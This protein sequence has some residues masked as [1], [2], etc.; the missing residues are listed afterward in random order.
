MRTSSGRSDALGWI[1]A[2]IVTVNTL[3]VSNPAYTPGAISDRRSTGGRHIKNLAFVLAF[4]VLGLVGLPASSY[5]HGNI[6]H[7]F[8]GPFNTDLS[9]EAGAAQGFTPFHTDIVAVDLFLTGDGTNPPVDLIVDVADGPVDGLVFGSGIVG[10]PAGI[11]GSPE[12]PYEVHVDLPHLTLISGTYY[13]VV[14]PDSSSI[15]WAASSS[16][17]YNLGDAYEGSTPVVGADAGFRTYFVDPPI[18][19]RDGDSIDDEVD[20]CPD[21]PN[22]D[23]FDSDF[24]GLGDACDFDNDNDGFDDISDNCPWAYNPDQFDSDFDGLGDACDYDADNDGI[25]DFGDNCPGTYNPDQGDWDLD[26]TG[27][28]C[29]F[30]ADNDGVE[31]FADNCQITYNP[32]QTDSDLDG[33]GDACDVDADNDGID[34]ATDNCQGTYNPDQMDFDVDGVGDACDFDGDNDGV[35]D[36]LDNCQGVYNP[37]QADSDLDTIGDAC[38]VDGD[39]DG[40]DDATDNCPSEPNTDQLNTDSDS[41]GDACDADDDNDAIGDESDNCVTTPNPDQADLDGDGIGDACDEPATAPTSKDECRRGGWML[42][43]APRTFNSQGDCI[44]FVNTGR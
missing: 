33:T 40:I 2:T 1:A 30:D 35:E 4:V 27:D 37:D 32:D 15:G 19:D 14:R 42:F 43:N 17:G 5:G 6:D 10:I 12:A 26:G 8:E 22:Y 24:D 13:I 39:N 18:T 11:S 44:Q 34:D 29:D 16:G 7:A 25:D 38:D 23:Q 28:A 41:L 20:N 36:F 21:T 9:L 3:H 31:D